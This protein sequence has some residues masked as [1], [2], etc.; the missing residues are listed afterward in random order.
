[1]ALSAYVPG[2]YPLD[3]LEPGLEETTFYDPPNFTFPNGVFVC[4]VESDQETG[5]VRVYR[6]VG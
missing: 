2:N 4:E 3:R 6:L 1:V 5:H